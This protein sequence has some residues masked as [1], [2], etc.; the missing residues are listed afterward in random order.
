VL[1]LLFGL[2][3]VIGTLFRKQNMALLVKELKAL[4]KL[5][6]SFKTYFTIVVGEDAEDL[7]ID[8]TKSV[9]QRL[10]HLAMLLDTSY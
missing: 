8:D 3:Q 5:E 9:E 2:K 4:N 1:H 6:Q 7:G 10:L